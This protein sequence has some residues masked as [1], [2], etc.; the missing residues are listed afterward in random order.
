MPDTALYGVDPVNGRSK[1]N[2]LDHTGPASYSLGGET[3]GQSAYGG[4]NTVGLNG[5]Q[6]AMP[7]ENFLILHVHELLQ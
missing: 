2:I 1:W 6:A 3:Y 5:Y 4:P 7:E